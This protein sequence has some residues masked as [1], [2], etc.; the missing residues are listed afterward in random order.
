MPYGDPDPTDPSMLVGVLLPG[1]Q[2]SMREMASVFA[3]EFAR[4]GYPPEQVLA[5]FRNPF[6]GGAHAA[7]QALGADAVCE[8]VK[9]AA[10]RWP[11]V[12]IV[13]A[14]GGVEDEAEDAETLRLAEEEA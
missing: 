3:D 7:L 13:D 14:P 8:I 11:R 12:R 2:D 5:L 9:E 4:M 10:A 6:Y 1:K